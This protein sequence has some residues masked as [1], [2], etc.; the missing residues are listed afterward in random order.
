MHIQVR[1]CGNQIGAKFWEVICNEHGINHIGTCHGELFLQWERINMYYNEVSRGC[2]VLR[3]ML[4]DL[5][6]GIMDNVRS[7]PIVHIFKPYNFVFSQMGM[8]ND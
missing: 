3:V 5:E 6:H 8:G 7:R 2:Y 4:M 1:H